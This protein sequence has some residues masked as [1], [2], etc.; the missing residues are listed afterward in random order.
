MVDEF[1]P[2][3]VAA[4]FNRMNTANLLNDSKRSFFTDKTLERFWGKVGV[5]IASLPINSRDDAAS[6]L[7]G[8]FLNPLDYDYHKAEIQKSG[9][10]KLFKTNMRTAQVEADKLIFKIAK[11]AGKLAEELEELERTIDFPP[12]GINLLMIVRQLI[13]D[14]ALR[15]PPSHHSKVCMSQAIRLL[16][17]N[18]KAHP[19]SISIFN[20]VPGM[21]SQKSSWVDWMREAEENIKTCLL[22]YPA[23]L[24]FSLGD[25]TNLVHVIVGNHISSKAIK[26]ARRSRPGK[27]VAS[28]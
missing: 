27:T 15:E 14:P 19:T 13:D 9:S 10:P 4:V 24:K 20:E 3:A 17:S 28:G 23:S 25:W 22:V 26:E 18:L 16:E 8:S 2:D 11:S 1:L 6:F 12:D 21:A 7:V 5:Y